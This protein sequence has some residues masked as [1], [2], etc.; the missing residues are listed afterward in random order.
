[1]NSE[2]LLSWQNPVTTGLLYSLLSLGFGCGMV[3]DRF[4]LIGV[5][6]NAG[7]LAVMGVVTGIHLG[8][9]RKE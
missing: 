5:G 3:L 8:L 4:T 6:L 7:V 2:R 9:I 1:M